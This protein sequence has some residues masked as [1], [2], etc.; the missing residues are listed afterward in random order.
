L[1]PYDLN[2]AIYDCS[3]VYF[4]INPAVY[5]SGATN[6]TDSDLERATYPG[7]NTNGMN[8][9]NSVATSNY[10]GLQVIYTQRAKSLT[11][12]GSY[13]YSRSLDLQSNGITTSSSVPRP[14]NLS[15]QYGPSDFQATHILNVGWTI[16]LPELRQGDR[17]ARAVLNNW[18]AG[19]L[20]SASTGNPFSPI[21]STD[22]MYNGEPNQRPPLA[23]GLSKYMPLP[24]NRHRVDK[25]SEWFNFQSFNSTPPKGY[26]NG[27]GRNSLYGPA[28]METDLRV[29]RAISLP[30][31]GMVFHLHADAFN[32]WNTPN[33][34]TPIPY[35]TS[36]AAVAKAQ[37]HG[38]IVSTVGRNGTVGTNGRRIQLSLT[39]QY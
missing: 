7:F 32:A 8:D 35:V 23:V 4:K 9:Q 28:Y 20:F 5:C 24:S 34:A 6:N 2:P 25:V 29:D 1:I 17:I 13:T 19:G 31:R 33:L 39:L 21:F 27:V 30:T 12:I 26:T 15:T 11:A 14:G 38:G 10:N 36:N 37:D 3:G 18:N 22:Q 16:H